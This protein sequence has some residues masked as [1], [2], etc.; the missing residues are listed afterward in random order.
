MTPYERYLFTLANVEIAPNP[1]PTEV[2]IEVVGWATDWPSVQLQQRIANFLNQL[3][4]RVDE[5]EATVDPDAITAALEAAQ[6]AAAAASASATAAH[7][8]AD[9]AVTLAAASVD[10]AS[11]ASS[12]ASLAQANAVAALDNALAASTS[13]QAAAAAATLAASDATSAQAW[14]AAAA[15]SALAAGA[16]ASAV[17]A[18]LASGT[19]ASVRATNLNPI[20]VANGAN[21]RTLVPLPSNALRPAPHTRRPSSYSIAEG[22]LHVAEAGLYKVTVSGIFV[23]GLLTTGAFRFYAAVG[24]NLAGPSPAIDDEVVGAAQVAL[25]S[26]PTNLWV[27]GDLLVPAGG[28]EVAVFAGHSAA[29]AASLTLDRLELSLLRCDID[30]P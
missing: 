28:A 20:V 1:T 4:G 11:A 8:S 6:A 13:S 30:Y 9:E 14:A 22:V 21:S 12:A 18:V 19:R 2:E 5:L 24:H 29:L 15:S 25:L 23:T 10:A 17:G 7:G 27:A 26:V 16:T 3:F